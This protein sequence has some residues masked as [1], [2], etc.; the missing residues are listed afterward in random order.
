MES[1]F[2][3]ESFLGRFRLRL[4]NNTLETKHIAGWLDCTVRH[5]QKWA[6]DN[7]VDHVNAGGRKYYI[8]D[9]QKIRAFAD[10]Y[11]RRHYR[12]IKIYY[13]SHGGWE[14]ALEAAMSKLDLGSK[15]PYELRGVLCREFNR[16]H[17]ENGYKIDCD[18]II[19]HLINNSPDYVET[20]QKIVDEYI[21][22]RPK[23]RKIYYK[24]RWHDAVE[25]AKPKLNWQSLD[26]D[27]VTKALRRE[28]DKQVLLKLQRRLN[29][30]L[31]KN[32]SD[33]LGKLALEMAE[34]SPE[35]LQEL[36]DAIDRIG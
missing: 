29:K 18:S 21:P 7:S 13:V 8:W 25:A 17:A 23:P 12:P 15:H 22:F 33:G 30:M 36:Q 32:P 26:E 3:V 28:F 35:F 5:V 2:E 19:I 9:E 24:A 11:N 20:L 4:E 14:T 34:K 6:I 31:G 27:R 10:H 16:V 1:F